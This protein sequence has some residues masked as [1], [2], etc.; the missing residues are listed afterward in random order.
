MRILCVFSTLLTRS[1]MKRKQPRSLVFAIA[2]GSVGLLALFF[3]TSESEETHEKG[4]Q[5]IW[6]I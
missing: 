4:R 6:V 2:I 3:I 1:V 5:E